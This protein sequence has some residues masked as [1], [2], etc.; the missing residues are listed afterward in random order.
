MPNY[1][2]VYSP[3]ATWFFTLV[4]YD[5]KPLLTSGH[6]LSCLRDA[7]ER[8][9]ARYPFRIDAI[10]V[11]PDHLHCLW[12]LPPGEK[13]FSRRWNMVK[14]LFTKRYLA[15]A[16]GDER[17]ASRRRT[18]EAAVWQRRFWEH[19]IRDDDDYARHL[20]YIHYNPVKHGHVSLP[21][22]WQ[23]SSF[24]RYLRL[25]WYEAHWGAEEPLSVKAVKRAG[26]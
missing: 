24:H 20:D 2:R 21:L 22:D 4:T 17:N 23:W 19:V 3:G 15:T 10:C 9:R 5:R 25:G 18:G 6:A 1:T 11:L 14:G 12:T 8:T 16:P 13:D 7:L 26:E